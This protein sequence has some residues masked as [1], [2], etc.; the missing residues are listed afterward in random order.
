METTK[1]NREVVQRVGDLVVDLSNEVDPLPMSEPAKEAMVMVMVANC[2]K[3]QGN[4]VTFC[5]PT[6]KTGL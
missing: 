3:S 6:F 1:H 4:I 2:L 5:L